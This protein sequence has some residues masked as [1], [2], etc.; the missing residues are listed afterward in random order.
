MPEIFRG[1]SSRAVQRCEVSIE[2]GIKLDTMSGIGLWVDVPDLRFFGPLGTDK[3]ILAT[4]EVEV[5]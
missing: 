3:G 4:H 1:V 2:P 5:A